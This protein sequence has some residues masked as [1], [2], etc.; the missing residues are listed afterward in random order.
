MRDLGKPQMPS[1]AERLKSRFQD[2]GQLCIGIDPSQPVLTDWGL[3]D[4]AEGA[5]DFG[6]AIISAAEGRVGL[7]KPQVAFFERFGSSGIFALEEV[8]VAAREV[9]LIII[10]DAKRGD[11]GSSMQGYAQAWFGD[12]SPL[13]SDALTVSPYLG[14]SSL[15]EIV[16]S[17]RDVE[18]GIFVLAATSN[19]E[20]AE[21]QIAKRGNQTVAAKVLRG[22][23]ELS[24]GDVGVVIG[25]TQELESFGIGQIKSVDIVVPILSPGFGTQGAQLSDLAGLFGA[26]SSRVI[27]SVSRALYSAGPKGIVRLIEDM[28]VQL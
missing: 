25:A 19:P 8:L 11:V 27:C 16:E 9:D 24:K 28:K 5:R 6:Y 12:D 13:R 14:P 3:P 23:A 26:S 20:A 7:I 1:F 2:Y 18:A 4:T 22:V 15:A 10:A 21:I 17:A